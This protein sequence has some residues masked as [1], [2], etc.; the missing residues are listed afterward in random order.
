MAFFSNDSVPSSVSRDNDGGNTFKASPPSDRDKKLIPVKSNN[1]GQM[2]PSVASRL[3]LS[4]YPT[5]LN[6]FLSGVDLASLTLGHG[7]F[8]EE[9]EGMLHNVDEKLPA[10]K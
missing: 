10:E 1:P 8:K 9:K 7:I 5:N 4:S 2:W 3:S 6:S